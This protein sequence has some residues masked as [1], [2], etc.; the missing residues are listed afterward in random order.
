MHENRPTERI[1]PAVAVRMRKFRP[2]QEPIRLLDLLNS[3]RSRAEKRINGKYAT[4]VPD[5]VSYEIYEWSI[6]PVKHSCLC[7]KTYYTNLM[8]LSTRMLTAGKHMQQ[9]FQVR[10]T[11]KLTGKN[12]SNKPNKQT[13]KKKNEINNYY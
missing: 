10:E 1:P 3:A 5:V 12:R 13:D 9:G 6:F 2:L 11:S 8:R 4:R 7:N